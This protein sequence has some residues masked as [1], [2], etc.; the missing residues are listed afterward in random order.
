M[1]TEIIV[2]IKKITSVYNSLEWYRHNEAIEIKDIYVP[3]EKRDFY[4]NDLIRGFSLD[5]PKSTNLANKLFSG[6]KTI[7]D[8]SKFLNS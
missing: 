8:I 4:L 1:N 6:L 5:H 7:N 2:K 3:S